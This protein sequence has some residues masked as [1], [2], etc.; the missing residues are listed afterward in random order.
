MLQRQRATEIVPRSKP[1]R[2]RPYDIPQ[3]LAPETSDA[4]RFCAAEGDLEL[5]DLRHRSTHTGALIA[6]RVAKLHAR[7]LGMQ[8]THMTLTGCTRLGGWGA[9]LDVAEETGRE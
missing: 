9:L 2:W 4:P 1:L 7:I 8:H 3:H 6:A 5:L